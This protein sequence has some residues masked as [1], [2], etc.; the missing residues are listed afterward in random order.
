MFAPS[1]VHVF[2]GE[3]VTPRHAVEAKLETETM[4]AFAPVKLAAVVVTLLPEEPAPALCTN[5]T[6]ALNRSAKHRNMIPVFI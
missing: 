2:A 5:A 6:A 1:A 3:L 4:I